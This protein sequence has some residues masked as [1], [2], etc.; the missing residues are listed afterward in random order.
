MDEPQDSQ[1][2]TEQEQVKAFRVKAD[3]L[4]VEAKRLAD[5]FGTSRAYSYRNG[6]AGRD[7]EISDRGIGATAA[8]SS[9]AADGCIVIAA[10][11]A[12]ACSD[13]LN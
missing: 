9:R 2:M 8:T 3:A 7:R 6:S 1:E 11:T 5:R 10:A 12:A 13:G 4:M